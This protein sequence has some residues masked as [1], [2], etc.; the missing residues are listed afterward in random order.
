MFD[1]HEKW[2]EDTLKIE[3]NPY[4]KVAAIFKG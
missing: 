2:V 3:D 1:E 4:I